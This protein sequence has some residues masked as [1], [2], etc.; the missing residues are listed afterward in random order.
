MNSKIKI[1]LTQNQIE[2]IF[3]YLYQRG[4]VSNPKKYSEYDLDM[5][6]FILPIEMV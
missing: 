5:P 6:P 2:A 4:P 1:P 3:V